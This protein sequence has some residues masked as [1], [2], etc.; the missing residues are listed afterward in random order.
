[1]PP[2]PVPVLLR[3]FAERF[4]LATGGEQGYGQKG[5]DH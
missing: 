4:L 1:L 3:C 2:V 5:D